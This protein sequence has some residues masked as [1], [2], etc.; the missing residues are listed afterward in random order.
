MYNSQSNLHLSVT[1]IQINGCHLTNG[2]FLYRLS[3]VY[4]L[5]LTSEV[6]LAQY[7]G[8]VHVHV[9]VP[10]LFSKACNERAPIWSSATPKPT[11]GH[12]Y[13]QIT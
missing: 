6:C 13:L 1:D 10:S 3:I 5:T 8:D 11:G 9:P 2:S 7:G 12:V 4:L